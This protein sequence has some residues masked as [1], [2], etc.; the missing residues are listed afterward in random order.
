MYRI[1]EI[2]PY[3]QAFESEIHLRMDH[4]KNKRKE[5]LGDVP[6]I[7]DF[8]NAHYY[9]GFHRMKNGWVYREWAPAAEAMYLT[10]DFNEW[11][12][13]SC[14]MKKLEHGVFE[15]EIEG[16]D[17]L[18]EGQKIQALV[19]HNGQKLRRIPLYA[20]RVVQDRETRLWCA[21]LE[22]TFA[23]FDWTD[24]DFKPAKVPLI[25]ECHIGM[26]QETYEVGTYAQFR[27][28]ILPRIKALG[29]N[30]IQIMAIM[31]HPYYGSFGYQVSNFYAA[32]S[33]YGK[34]VELKKLINTAHEMGITVL[35]DVVHSHAVKNTSEGLN[36]FDGTEYQFFHSGEKGNHSAWGTKLFHYGKNEVLHFLLSNLKYWMEVFHFDGFR[37]DGVTSMLYH[38]HGLGS[39]F[40]DYSMYFSMNTDVEAITYL[41]LANELIH[42]IHP[43][44]I[45]VAEDMSG[46]PGMCIPI[47]DGGIGF[48]Y[49]L[50]MGLPDLWIRLLKESKDED[51]DM[52][53]IWYELTGR[54][55]EE[56]NIGYAESHDQALVGD[57]T[58]MFRLCDAQMYS[59]M[60]K[61]SGNLIVERGVALHKMIRLLT[62]SVA[63][64]GYLNFMGNE[65]GHPEW[66]DF[67][68]EGNGW[69]HHYCRRQWSLVDNE[70][71]HYCELNAFDQAMI[72]LLTVENI[73]E[74]KAESRWIH[75][76]DKIL[77]YNKGD[78]VFA[79]NFHPQKSF[80]GYWIP[81][82]E[83]GTYRV[84]LSTDD[85]KFGGQERID[86]SCQYKVQ[87]TQADGK[88]FSCYLPSRTAMVLK[89]IETE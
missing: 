40:V 23:P 86:T 77:I 15:V 36:E 73:L 63:G 51:W 27:E 65:F 68:R 1:L 13:E 72:Q 53:K 25:Y 17:T 5:L 83:E 44:A 22:E 64:E 2:D 59:G 45:T 37:F 70:E 76:D 62:A 55:P 38:N 57:K 19:V 41:Q 75:Q 7:V 85:K 8:A 32:S 87:C 79:F 56:K 6:N 78:V 20:T 31:E 54:R 11:N 67:P 47:E 89:K 88:G 24:Q 10:G 52:G 4:Y 21:E 16:A 58:I 3:L 28:K 84:I 26:A 43:K 74:Q 34:S 66:I 12:L 81:V 33:R 50:S 9:F 69:S 39:A 42:T 18:A 30:T 60:N 80:E 14:P 35:L 48:D 46:M 61:N 71:L 29:Y 82:A 49:R